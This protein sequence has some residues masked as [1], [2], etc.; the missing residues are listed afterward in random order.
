MNQ[1]AG[2]RESTALCSASYQHDEHAA[3]VLAPRTGRIELKV[4]NESDTPTA[5]TQQLIARKFSHFIRAHPL[6]PVDTAS[7]KEHDSGLYST[8]VV[9][10][11]GEA[12]RFLS[13]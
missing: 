13:V 9:F 1:S 6:A 11:A 8:L 5:Q 10:L 7:T 3:K 2:S 4:S 12:A